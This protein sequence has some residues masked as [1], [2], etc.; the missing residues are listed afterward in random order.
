MGGLLPTAKALPQTTSEWKLAS[1][2][3]RLIEADNMAIIVVGDI[4]EIRPEL[5]AL[6]MPIKVL[7]EEGL[8]VQDPHQ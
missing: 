7:D 5:E 3:G 4:P 1:L 8:E 6:G 2:A